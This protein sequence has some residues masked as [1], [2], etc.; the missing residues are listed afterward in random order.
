MKRRCYDPRRPNYADYGG[1]GIRV[2]VQWQD[3]FEQFLTDVGHRPGAG[4]SV[5][6][7]N[8]NGDYE[9]GNV[10]WATIV[11]QNR[12]QRKTRR[13]LFGDAVLSG[14]EFARIIGRHPKQIYKRLDEGW[15]PE[16]IAAY[17]SRSVA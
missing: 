10:V 11:E 15:T 2:C 14:A 12:N 1:R 8:V 4:Y 6:R 5:E 3:S 7:Q 16:H 9:P 13:I 17:Y